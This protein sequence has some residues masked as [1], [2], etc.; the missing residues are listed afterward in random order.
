MKSAR[1][2]LTF[3]V[4][5]TAQAI[6]LIFS[7][8][9]GCTVKFGSDK[10]FCGN[11][12]LDEDETCDG[13]DFGGRKCS[14]LTDHT[15]GEL[16]CTDECKLNFS[17]CHSCGNNQI[18]GPELCDRETLGGET[19]NTQ[20]FYGGSL[21][22]LSDCLGF[23]VSGCEGTCGD[24]T[25]NGDEI[26]DNENLDGESCSTR[27]YHSGELSCLSDCSGFDTSG[28]GVCGDD[29]INGDETCDTNN[30]G[31]E[32]CITQGFEGGDLACLIDCSGFDF[33]GCEGTGPECGDNIKEGM[34]IC[35]GSDLD[36]QT[37]I[38]QGFDGGDLACLS[39][40]SSF[41]TSTCFSYECGNN[42]IEPGEICDGSDLDGQSC[43][44]QDFDGGELACLADCSGFDLT[45][46]YNYTCGDGTIN[47]DED[48]D[49][50]DLGG[51]DTCADFGCRVSGAITCNDDCTYSLSACFSEHDEDGDGV[52]DN[53]DNCPSYHN[54]D[55]ADTN[56]DGIGD[57][58][59]Y[60]GDQELLSSITIF[61]PFLDDESS[62]D[63]YEGIWEYGGDAV[64]G[65]QITSGG[66]YLHDIVLPNEP[67]A[68]ETTFHF[69]APDPASNSWTGLIF[70]WTENTKA[71]ACHFNRDET[72]FGIWR[73]EDYTAWNLLTSS[74][75]STTA[76]DLHW[77]KLHV[78][79]DG[80]EV[81]C[82]YSDETGVLITIL[83][84]GNQVWNEMSGQTGI[85]VYNERT[86]FTSFTAYQ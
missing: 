33:S 1:A 5:V 49:G 61:D 3:F 78:I 17:Q 14:D 76:D 82:R 70:A 79:Y 74:D 2:P 36:N 37:C 69:E 8:T 20:G 63:E 25:I 72:S 75:I 48:C 41:D 21:A 31:G 66:N 85:R 32:T 13:T 57:V 52:D 23:D 16:V 38:T 29:I 51:L 7:G 86:V 46:C 34:E 65:R 9:T 42:N 4:M 77:R 56:G 54:A 22:C 44:S 67:Y 64:E 30:Y 40:C 24:G 47:N 26:C 43:I 10:P 12:V 11:G 71:Y 27:G 35:D 84:Q 62:W 19:C 53:C 28:C 18:E 6:V 60:L 45:G 15:D 58:C 50:G 55:Q 81:I 39:D 73:I 83:A 68:V 59:E 80:S